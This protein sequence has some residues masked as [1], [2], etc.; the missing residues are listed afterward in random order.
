MQR[1]QVSLRFRC[2][3][4]LLSRRILKW[5]ISARV[6]RELLFL[7]PSLTT[8]GPAAGRVES[9]S[10]PPLEPLDKPLL[11]IQ[12]G[13]IVGAY[14]ISVVF[15]L[16][17]FVFVGRR[18]RR[19][20]QASNYSLQ[21]EMMTPLKP[22][23]AVNTNPVGTQA[24]Q[25]STVSP[26]RTSAFTGSFSS[27]VKGHKHQNSGNTS[28]VT[29]DETVVASDRRRAQDEMEK[30]YAAVMEHDELKAAGLVDTS[31]VSYAAPSPSLREEEP[32]T[33][34]LP[35]PRSASSRRSR[36]S[37]LSLFS[38]SGR[39]G[40]PVSSDKLHSPRSIRKL[41]IIS[42]PFRSPVGSTHDE[43]HIP[44]S[45]RMYKPGPPP[46]APKAVSWAK[47]SP[48]PSER[49]PAPAPLNLSAG[50]QP[51]STPS[52]PLREAYPPSS[53]P[54]TK[55]TILERPENLQRMGG[56]R[57]GLATPYSPYMPFTPV[58]PITPSHIV[59][60][61]QRRQEGREKGLQVLLEDD[62]VKASDDMWGY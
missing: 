28:V 62:M 13:C 12:V 4:E 29:I 42:P 22:S 17:L 34:P 6:V 58:T 38:S 47:P 14:L 61:R 53:A 19:A 5:L 31:P 10:Y 20:V 43:E 16:T 8:A 36:M 39:P 15:L 21:V 60:K 49:A 1:M 7:L 33:P 50:S 26:S 54:A 9:R 46:P 37:P 23:F 11:A 56:P 25:P 45:P 44:L 2:D 35:S 24:T 30:L 55:T 3:R 40:N 51:G 57:T 27:L 48:R 59:T 32:T 18:L 52:L 41:P